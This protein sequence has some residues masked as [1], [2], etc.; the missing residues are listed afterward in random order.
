MMI[1]P[2]VARSAAAQDE[3]AGVAPPTRLRSSAEVTG[4]ELVAAD[5]V[6]GTLTDFIVADDTWR[7]AYLAV[8]LEAGP[9]VVFPPEWVDRINW[10]EQRIHVSVAGQQIRFSPAYGA[11]MD[12]TPAYEAELERHY[13]KRRV[14]K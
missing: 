1:G 7:I 13:G 5:G 14:W 8:A 9:E 6:V 11:V 4:Y 10:G 3:A 2:S 12:L